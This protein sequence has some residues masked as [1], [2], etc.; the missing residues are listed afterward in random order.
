MPS[1]PAATP[2]KASG[3]RPRRAQLSAPLILDAAALVVERDGPAALT[4]RKLGTELGVNHTAVLRHFSGK[5]QI[6]LGLAERVLEEALEGFEPQGEWDDAFA[7]LARRVRAAYLV[8]P[9]IA[10]LVAARVSRS[11]AEFRGAELVLATFERAGFSGRDAAV[12]YRTVTDLTLALSAYE[13]SVL[14]MDPAARAGDELAMQREY[15]LA[16]AQ[17]FPHLAKAAP[18]L[19][20]ISNDEIFESALSLVIDGIRFRRSGR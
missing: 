11:Q 15:L 20:G 1:Q 5:D 8:H 13:A 9:G 10:S 4:L 12:L 19:A 6:V 7:Q 3:S 18:E 2:A 17:E 16:P 14:V